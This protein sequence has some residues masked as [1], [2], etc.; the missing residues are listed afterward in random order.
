MTP[1]VLDVETTT[2]NKG[3]PYNQDNKLCYL[4][5]YDGTHV[6][7]ATQFRE[8]KYSPHLLIVFNGKFDLTWLR[9]YGID[10]SK[11]TIWDCQLAHFILTGQR[12]V[13]PSLNEVSEHYGLGSKLDIVK[14][15]Y[16]DK[17]ID[18]PDIPVEVLTEYLEQ[19]LRLTWQIYQ[20]QLEDFSG[21]PQLYKLF[22][23]QCEDLLVLLEMEWNGLEINLA[24]CKQKEKEAEKQIAA[25]EEQLQTYAPDV[26]INWSSND[27]CSCLLFG[28]TIEHETKIPIGIYKS[29]KKEGEIR[30]KNLIYTYELP[31]LCT[32][33]KGSELQKPGY[34][35]TDEPTLR[36]LKTSKQIRILIELLLERSRLEKLRGTY[37][38]GIADKVEELNSADG[39]VHG[40]FNQVVAATGRLSSS[41]PNLQNFPLELDRLLISRYN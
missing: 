34:Y 19:D 35:S 16:W 10:Y 9:R 15:E 11:C 22:Q 39:R 14:L 28:G 38:K 5:E 31:R 29:G 33:L 18:T 36:S 2:K 41:K 6:N 13:M 25:I 12:S 4:G 8:F 30:Y 21:Y 24:S 17:G 26:P 40:Q 27:H 37:Y 7:I 23:L 32:P 3:N 1:L 20:K